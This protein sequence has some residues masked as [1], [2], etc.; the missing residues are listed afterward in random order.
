MA[1]NAE[2]EIGESGDE[3]AMA[4]EG[5]PRIIVQWYAN[6]RGEQ[7]AGAVWRPGWKDTA[8]TI[9]PLIFQ[10]DR[11]VAGRG[12][13]GPVLRYTQILPISCISLHGFTLT[14]AGKLRAT[15]LAALA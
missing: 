4:D 6:A 8:D 1:D 10:T 5:E 14:K 7:K 3:G 13:K 9:R 12:A 2:E 11:P 15:T